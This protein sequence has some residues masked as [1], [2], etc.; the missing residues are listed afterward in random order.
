MYIYRDDTSRTRA[1]IHAA[2]H[3]TSIY[4]TSAR[5]DEREQICAQMLHEFACMHAHKIF[6][7]VKAA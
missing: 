7:K 4:C 1:R 6:L 3:G 5:A 2:W